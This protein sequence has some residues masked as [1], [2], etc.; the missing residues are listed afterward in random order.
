M[1]EPDCRPEHDRQDRG[2]RSGLALQTF[3]CDEPAHV[4]VARRRNPELT[5][6][7]DEGPSYLGYGGRPASRLPREAFPKSRIQP[8]CRG[9]HRPRVTRSRIARVTSV[10]QEALVTLC[11]TEP[12]RI[13]GLTSFGEDTAGE[14]YATASNGIVYRL[15]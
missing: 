7:T 10:R 13:V 12:I 9:C 6:S 1:F 3:E 8:R 4:L 14:L 2:L 15:T 5:C 11:R